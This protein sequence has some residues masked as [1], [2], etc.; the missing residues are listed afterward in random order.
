MLRAGGATVKALVLQEANRLE[1]VDAPRPEMGTGDVLVRVRACGICGSDVHG[2]DGSTGRRRPPIVMGHEAAGVVEAVGEAVADWAP[3]RRVTFDSTVYCGRCRH[4]RRGEINLCDSRQVLGVACEDY[5]RQGAMAEYVAVPQHIVCALPEGL[6]FEHAAMVE[7]LS[8]AVHAVERARPAVGASAVVV[9]AGMIGLLAVQVLR[10]AGCG[11]I[12][13]V[14]IDAD[15]LE[16]ARALGADAALHAEQC[17]VPAEVRGRTGGRGADLALEVFGATASVRTALAAVRKGGTVVLIG[18]VSPEVQFPLQQAVVRELTVLGSCASRG[19]YPVC[20][21]LL[22]R[23]A[24]DA[25][26]L[27]SAVAPLE[28]APQWFAR[29]QRREPGLMK[30]I[31]TP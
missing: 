27:I 25:A 22:T 3:G 15:H 16:R 4:C 19:E 12:V 13:A 21:D 29:L 28:E 31:L 24:V 7:P 2:M 18:N 6:P 26:A 11:T 1:I 20:L 9:G 30:V 23:G 5:R 17:D 14:D 8:V 10:H